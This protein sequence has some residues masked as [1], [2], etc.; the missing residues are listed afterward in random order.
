[1]ELKYRT[2]SNTAIAGDDF[3]SREGWLTFAHHESMKTIEIPLIVTGKLSHHNV[4]FS[5]DLLLGPGD[6]ELGPGEVPAD[7]GGTPWTAGAIY[8]AQHHRTCV[9]AISNDSNFSNIVD[10]VMDDL[11]DDDGNLEKTG[12]GDLQ[13]Q[14]WLQQFEDAIFHENSDDDDD[15]DEDEED[16]LEVGDGGGSCDG[17]AD[18]DEAPKKDWNCCNV[19]T[20]SNIIKTVTRMN[21]LFTH[22]ISIPWNIFAA[23]APPPGMCGG[24]PTFVVSLAMV[25]FVTALIGDVA[26][27]CVLFPLLSVIYLSGIRVCMH[28]EHALRLSPTV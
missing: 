7:G 21:T 27:E 14:S 11:F 5:V 9:V 3:V 2:V 25:G 24:Y 26:S 16:D 6:E 8:S 1:M 18:G 20:L 4:M 12:W 10:L 23:C 19:C 13:Q 15:D 17:K 28:C 22:A